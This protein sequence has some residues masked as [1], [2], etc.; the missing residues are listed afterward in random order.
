MLLTKTEA[1]VNEYGIH[2]QRNYYNIVITKNYHNFSYLKIVFARYTRV[3]GIIWRCFSI[4]TSAFAEI[5][6]TIYLKLQ[7]NERPSHPSSYSSNFQFKCRAWCSRKSIKET[8]TNRAKKKRKERR[9][10]TADSRRK[11]A[12]LSPRVLY[13]SGAIRVHKFQPIILNKHSRVGAKPLVPM[14]TNKQIIL[15]SWNVDGRCSV[16]PLSLVC[17]VWF[18]G[19]GRF[20][21]RNHGRTA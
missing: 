16:V 2:K 18:A 13:E 7:D 6:K 9:K 17:I 3:P 8:R 14:Q 4:F 5:K 12:A 21:L 19:H 10:R 15:S 20:P 1:R 11:N